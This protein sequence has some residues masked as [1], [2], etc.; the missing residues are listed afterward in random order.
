[1]FVAGFFVAGV[2]EAGFFIGAERI[3]ALSGAVAR[4]NLRLSPP[5]RGVRARGS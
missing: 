3:T 5:G 4:L 2:F 1:M